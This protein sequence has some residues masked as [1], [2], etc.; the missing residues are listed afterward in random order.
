MSLMYSLTNMLVL[1]PC[2]SKCDYFG[3]VTMSLLIAGN[4]N[5]LTSLENGERYNRTRS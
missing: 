2:G 3:Q 5:R 1:C 4:H